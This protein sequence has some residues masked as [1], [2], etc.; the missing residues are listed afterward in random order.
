MF[1]PKRIIED[2]AWKLYTGYDSYNETFVVITSAR[3][4]AR[5]EESL[6][7]NGEWSFIVS[8]LEGAIYPY[9]AFSVKLT[10]LGQRVMDTLSF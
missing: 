1:R 7:N 6:M 3:N 9:A 8:E 5:F 4:N 2:Y 10:K